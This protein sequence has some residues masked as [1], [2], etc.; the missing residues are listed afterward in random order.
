MNPK[1][2]APISEAVTVVIARLV[3]D[4]QTGT[5][6]PSHSSLEFL[7][8]RAGLSEGD[9]K[10]QGQLVGKRKRL[11]STL[12]WALEHNPC[13]G[14]DL[15]FMVISSLRAAGGFRHGSSNYVGEEVIQDAI[16]VFH[17]EGYEL[18]L[19]GELSPL[20][21]DGLSGAAMTEALKAYVRRAKRGASDAAL[22]TGTSKDLLEATAAHL[23][24]VRYGHDPGKANFPTLLEWAFSSL[25]MATPKDPVLPEESANRGF[26]RAIFQLACA[27]NRLRN[28][29]GTGHGRAWLPSVTSA[30]AKT[31]I[32][33]MGCIAECLLSAHRKDGDRQDQTSI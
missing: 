27:V 30:Q 1:R 29:E 12:S 3:D 18:S 26:E 21:L 2:S 28:K 15:V 9:P 11:L 22:L 24:S 33:L 14:E 32:E 23:V 4:A 20:V 17:A 25:R 16:T 8:N 7:I 13:A 31:A 5:R 6:E 19:D 10:A